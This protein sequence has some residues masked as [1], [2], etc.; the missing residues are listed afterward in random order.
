[1]QTENFTNQL[2]KDTNKQLKELNSFVRNNQNTSSEDV[3]LYLLDS[4][5]FNEIVCF[6][7]KKLVI[8]F[9]FRGYDCF[10]TI[11]RGIVSKAFNAVCVVL[12]A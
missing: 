11:S 7:I 4:D 9:L 1:M 2:A 12:K 8:P 6:F 5:F 3:S 10:V